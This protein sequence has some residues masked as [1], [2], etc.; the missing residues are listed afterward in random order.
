MDYLSNVE[1]YELFI[2]FAV[3]YGA[4]MSW[5]RVFQQMLE[6]LPN[7]E[8][9][10]IA[11]VVYAVVFSIVAGLV[12]QFLNQKASGN[13]NNNNNNGTQENDS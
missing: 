13:N 8:N 2:G 9:K 10:M 7:I 4:V 11:A 6:Y 12:L 1:L 5:D 3:V